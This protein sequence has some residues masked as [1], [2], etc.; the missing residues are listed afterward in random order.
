[1]AIAAIALTSCKKDE[2][3]TSELG[4]ATITGNVWADLDQTDDM[5]NGIFVQSLN[6]EG[7]EGMQV[8]VELN[9]S[10]LVQ[11]TVGGYDYEVRT[12]TATTAANG[13]YTLTL[14]AT[15]DAF[16]VT[17]QYQDI[18]TTRTILA[19]DGV[20]GITEDVEVTLGNRS[21]TIFSG[22]TIAMKDEAS[23]STVN[24]SAENYGTATMFGN[25]YANWHAGMTPPAGGIGSEDLAD[26]S[27][28][29][30]GK[31][32]TWAYYDGPH[33]DGEYIWYSSAIAAD[34]SYSFDLT[35]EGQGGSTVGIYWGIT[36]FIGDRTRMNSAFTADST[37]QAVY[38]TGG[39]QNYSTCCF[40]AGE[41]RQFD[42]VGGYISVS[43]L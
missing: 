27:S 26:A 23:V 35:T 20:T 5:Q 33:G 7:V 3:A 18:Y 42:I 10:N 39:V 8:S 24:T 6:P 31:S 21:A 36:D 9:T 16:S 41:L 4:S 32:I 14:P 1:M 11:N 28:P 2:P 17:L 13:D 22:A 38:S 19:E 30:S 25:V 12:Y 15:E 43:E 34:G 37:C 29:F 40:E